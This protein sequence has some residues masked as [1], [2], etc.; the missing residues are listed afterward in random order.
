MVLSGQ[1]GGVLWVEQVANGRSW[2]ILGAKFFVKWQEETKT[3]QGCESSD[4]EK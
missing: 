4:P 2:A 1:Y 3:R